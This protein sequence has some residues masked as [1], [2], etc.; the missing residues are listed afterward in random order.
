LC[1]FW[2]DRIRIFGEGLKLV[3]TELSILDINVVS[4]EL[5]RGIEVVCS[6]SV[7]SVIQIEIP[8]AYQGLRFLDILVPIQQLAIELLH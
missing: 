6:F 1:R 2:K 8:I 3:G 7:V 4:P 5:D